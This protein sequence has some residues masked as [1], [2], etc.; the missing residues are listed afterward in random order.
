MAERTEDAA[1]VG[2]RGLNVT[3]KKPHHEL[4]EFLIRASDDGRRLAKRYSGRMSVTMT[5]MPDDTYRCIVR[6]ADK[7]AV[8]V[9]VGRPARST[10]ATDAPEA[11]DA[12]ASAAISFALEEKDEHGIRVLTDHSV[13]DE[14]ERVIA[15]SPSEDPTLK[16]NLRRKDSK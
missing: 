7:L 10:V 6:D 12:A 13:Y 4:D 15:R 16:N 3:E 5:L 14:H 8:S 1:S 9:T 11:F 2:G